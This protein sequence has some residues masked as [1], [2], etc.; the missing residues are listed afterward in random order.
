MRR[1]GQDTRGIA[2]I[3][4]VGTLAVLGLLAVHIMTLSEISA[5]EAKVAVWRARLV[6]AGESAAD[7][8]FWLLLADR[9][10]YPTRTLGVATGERGPDASDAYMTDGRAHDYALNGKTF[11]FE[12]ATGEGGADG[13]G[14]QVSVRIFDAQ[15]GLDLSGINPATALRQQLQGEDVQE[16]DEL[17]RFLDVLDDAIDADETKRLHGK[18]RDDYTGEGFPDLPRNAPMQTRDEAFWLDGVA[19]VLARAQAPTG[20]P[21]GQTLNPDLIRVIPPAGI[22]APRQQ[23]PSFLATPPGL[24]RTLLKLTPDEYQ[25]ILDARQHWLTTGQPI[26]D[27]LDDRLYQRLAQRFSF[28]ESGIGTFVVTASIPGGEI[29]REWR[30]TRDCRNLRGGNTGTPALVYWDKFVP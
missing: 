14:L 18:E 23:L 8:A 20:E 30:C 3:M 9:R 27:S 17:D 28:A 7:R 22:F 29:R 21:A 12:P 4:V 6:Y 10:Q 15:A 13:G 11:Q 1:T 25:A 19:G 24:V 26:A 5:R 2:L 16:N